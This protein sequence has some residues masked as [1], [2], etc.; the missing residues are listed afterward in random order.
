MYYTRIIRPVLAKKK[1][2][3]GL[4]DLSFEE[5]ASDNEENVDE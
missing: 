4:D 1:S 5:K 2:G 3:R